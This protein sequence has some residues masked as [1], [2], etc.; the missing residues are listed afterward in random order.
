MV[1]RTL[2]CSAALLAASSPLL[3][4]PAAAPTPENWTVSA[5][6]GLALTSGNKDTS[7]VNMGYETVYDPKTRNLVKSDG[8]F[9]RGKTDGE[10][11]T[12]RLGLNGRDE[13]KLYK[14]AY[15]FGQVQYLQD[16]F[17][18]IDYLFS[19]AAGLGYRFADSA[20]TKLSA[21]AGLGA[22]WEKPLLSEVHTSGAVTLGEKLSHQLSATTT[23]TQSFAA[24]YKT[25]DFSDSL[26]TFGA[27]VAVAVAGHVQLKV[28]LLDTY[29]HLVVAPTVGNDVAVIVGLVFKR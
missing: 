20:R 22:V 4:Q 15:A 26:Y 2:A 6:A 1:V 25:D 29:K 12:D 17:K 27:G 3:A 14:R 19:P 7:T 13:Y 18:N 16:Q 28:E 10:L 8:L 11:T 24:L 21:D 9:L 5:T 23:L